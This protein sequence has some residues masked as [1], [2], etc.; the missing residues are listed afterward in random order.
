MA[1][2][3]TPDT[4]NWLRI[5]QLIRRIDFMAD[6]YIIEVRECKLFEILAWRQKISYME[7]SGMFLKAVDIAPKYAFQPFFIAV[8]ST[9]EKIAVSSFI[10]E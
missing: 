8:D 4:S 9:L 6:R 5:W 2:C 1:R 3:Q 10:G 7:S